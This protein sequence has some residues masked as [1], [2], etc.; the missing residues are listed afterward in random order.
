MKSRHP[1]GRK[2]ARHYRP[3]RDE[4]MTNPSGH[5]GRKAKKPRKEVGHAR[6]EDHRDAQ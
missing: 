5:K 2:Q 3:E 4:T 1:K 6:P